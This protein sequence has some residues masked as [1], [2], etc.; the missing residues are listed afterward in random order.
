MRLGQCYLNGIGV[1]VNKDLAFSLFT[2]SSLQGNAPAMF[3]L[4]GC[5]LNGWGT[6]KDE[7]AAIKYLKK[8]TKGKHAQSCYVLA[9]YYLKGKYVENYA[10][11]DL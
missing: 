4:F 9:N 10:I 11:I 6:E 2:K 7:N 8:A 3:M 5:Y 1:D